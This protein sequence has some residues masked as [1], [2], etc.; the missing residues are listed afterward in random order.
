MIKGII[1]DKDGTLFGFASSWNSWALNMIEL[2]APN[3]AQHQQKLAD[4]WKFS[5]EKGAFL[6]TSPVIA[7]TLEESARLGAM[8]LPSYHWREIYEILTKKAEM[9]KM[10]PVTPLRPLMTNL[11]SLGIRIGVV[12]NDTIGAT[13]RHLVQENILDVFDFLAGADSGF[14]PKPAPDALVTF[15]QTFFIKT[16]ECVM[17]GDSLHDL[18]A[19]KAAGMKTIGVLSGM[20]PATELSPFASCILPDIGTLYD[21]IRDN[22]L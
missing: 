18:R 19:G 14:T 12:T 15:A 16:S 13:R 5:L 10:V 3:N 8:V 6:P 2:L 1:F 4:I 22:E 21:V 11:K 7:G 17:I 9:Q 20:T